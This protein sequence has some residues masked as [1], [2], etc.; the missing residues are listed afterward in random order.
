MTMEVLNLQIFCWNIQSSSSVT[1]NKFNDN[2]FTSIFEGVPIVCLQET[3]QSIKY[4]GYRC[5][6]HNR[7]EEKHGGVCTLVH[8]SISKGITQHSSSIPD[9]LIIKLASHFFNLPYDIYVVNCYI[10][11]ANSSSKTI[12]FNGTDQLRD[13]QELI[14]TLS[15]KGKVV[16]CGDFNSRIGNDLDYIDHDDRHD[17][18]SYI[19]LPDNIMLPILTKR[20]TNDLIS[21]SHKRPFLEMVTNNGLAILNGRTTGDIH[22][23][24]TC[25]RPTGSSLIDYFIT[26]HELIDMTQYLTVK[27]LTIFSDHCP[28]ILCF[29]HQFDQQKN[30]QKDLTDKYSYAPFRYKFTAASEVIFKEELLKSEHQEKL[31]IILSHQYSTDR[32]G[33]YKLNEDVTSFELSPG[34]S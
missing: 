1:G 22:G 33:A 25:I 8:N 7:K 34:Q 19:P 30:S 14:G 21:N 27:P 4:S 17:G 16:L 32:E 2:S 3:R 13:L 29:D 15:G 12:S 9:I 5:Y 31:G 24:V 23:N 6:N 11:P 20:D 18:T 26:S 28:L 10:R